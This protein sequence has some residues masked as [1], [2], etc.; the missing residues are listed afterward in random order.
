MVLGMPW[1]L[2]WRNPVAADLCLTEHIS[3]FLS[4]ATSL[5]PDSF[6]CLGHIFN[7]KP[8]FV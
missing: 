6:D 3:P 2:C 7:I 8:R 4:V 5:P 1:Y